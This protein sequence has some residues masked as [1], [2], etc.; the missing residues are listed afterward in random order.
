[1]RD[2]PEAGLVLL[3]GL[4]G[5]D[6]L[7]DYHPFYAARAD[8]LRRLGRTEAAADAYRAA[9]LVVGNDPERTYLARRLAE[10]TG[11]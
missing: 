10:L 1:M 4:Q 11:Q 2:G 7:R 9:L 3:D 6:G 5:A 8:L